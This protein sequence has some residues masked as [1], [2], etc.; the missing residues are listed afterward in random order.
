MNTRNLLV[1]VLILVC[2]L[3]A[4]C[5][6]GATASPIVP[7]AVLAATVPATEV[8]DEFALAGDQIPDKLLD[9]EY[10]S[11]RV[12]LHLRSADDPIC[13]ELKTQN[14]CFTFLRTDHDP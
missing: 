8:P 4:A 3:L 10:Q 14:N 2:V 11:G 7:T 1:S 9:V 12:V 13:Q 5:G 6:P